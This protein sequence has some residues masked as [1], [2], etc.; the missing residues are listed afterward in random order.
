VALGTA[1]GVAFGTVA[2]FAKL[3]YRKGAAALPVLTGRFVVATVLLV[4]F[5]LATRRPLRAR[6]PAAIKLFLL[7]AVGL[8][9]EALL[10]FAA[11]ERA[12]ASVVGLVFYSYPAWTTL[13]GLALGLEAI[14]R[15]TLLA[16]A[17]GSAGVVVVFSVPDAGSTGLW[18]ALGSAFL[19]GV[20]LPVAQ[21]VTRGID[22]Y[23]GAVWTA[24]GASAALV[25][26]TA[27]TGSAV[28]LGA[29]PEL[30]ALGLATA[31]AYGLLYRALP[32]IG[33]SRLAIAMMVEPIAT[34]VLAAIVLDE[35]MTARVAFGAVL[36]VAALSLLAT[37]RRRAVLAE[38]QRAH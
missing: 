6:R 27:V 10:F 20:Y 26:A 2:I 33:A 31:L 38:V 5:G 19:V 22:P 35:A 17:L 8:G 21:R 24:I 11:L 34:L 7:G 1:S 13:T 15:R 12:P 25:T 30:F 16:L 37:R 28:P 32:L 9:S 4:L 23:A 18:I 29:M 36:I 3:A 14:S